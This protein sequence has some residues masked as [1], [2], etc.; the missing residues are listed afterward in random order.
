M[1]EASSNSRT[2]LLYT[3]SYVPEEIVL[4]AGFRPRRI[5]PEGR[6]ADAWIHPNTCGYVKNVLAA[7]LDAEDLGAAGI[8]VAN[9]C[10]AMRR[11]YDLW[12][13]YVPAVPAFFLDVPKKADEASVA[14]FAAELKRFSEW[15]HG[16]L[17]GARV[18]E[19]KLGEATRTCN[20]IR[21]LMGEVFGLQRA[22]SNGSSGARIFDLCLAGVTRSKAGFAA[23]IRR[24]LDAAEARSGETRRARIVV[25]GG[26]NSDRHVVAEIER[27]GACVVALDTCIGMRNYEQCVEDGSDPIAALARR[28]LAGPTCARM[29]G[30]EQRIRRIEELVRDARADGVV[31]CSLKF[32]DPCLY[33]APLISRAFREQGI[34]LLW[35][36]DDYASSSLGQTRTRIEA[37][38][39]LVEQEEGGARC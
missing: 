10:D 18:T 9:S 13:G 27:A 26:L 28:Y 19:T 21:S 2:D 7:G 16:V 32:C 23:D 37:F 24:L 22:A 25:T 6:P 1:S 33:D 30:L 15:L 20:E 35:L 8:V 36:E 17:A 4:A 29:E 38:L 14:F 3:C 12:T 39:E 34:P 11:L 5:L 31:Y